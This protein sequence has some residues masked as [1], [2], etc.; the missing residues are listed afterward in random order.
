MT[1]SYLLSFVSLAQIVNIEPR[2]IVSSGVAE[3][4][5]MLDKHP[6]KPATPFISPLEHF[7][8]G[9]FVHVRQM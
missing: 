9:L 1:V 4:S 8:R 3:A 6:H 2:L 7:V 5:Y